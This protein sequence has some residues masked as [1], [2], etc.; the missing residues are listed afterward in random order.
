MPI[1]TNLIF[2]CPAEHLP[3]LARSF[4]SLCSAA[5]TQS[6]YHLVG[7]IKHQFVI[8]ATPAAASVVITPESADVTSLG[9]TVR[10]A[11][12]ALDAAGAQIPS[13]SITWTTLD[14]GIAWR[15]AASS[16]VMFWLT[17]TWAP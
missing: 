14:P 1:S 6:G 7:G 13:A 12:R 4:W 8:Q 5:G 11:A 17:R 2:A 10:F 16:D 3:G 9:D 15:S